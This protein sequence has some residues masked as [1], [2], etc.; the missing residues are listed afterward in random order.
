[1]IIIHRILQIRQENIETHSSWRMGLN[2][3]GSG[4]WLQEKEM[5]GEYKFGLMA[6]AM[7]D[8]GGKIKPTEEADWSMLMVT[9]MKGTGLT[10][11]LMDMVCI[12]IWMGRDMRDIGRKIN[13][14]E[15]G[16]RLGLMA[17]YMMETMWM[18]RSTGRGLSAGLTQ[19]LTRE[20]SMTIIY[21]ALGLTSGLMAGSS[22]ES[23]GRTKCM[24][25]VFSSGPM[26][27]DTKEAMLMIKKKDM[28]YLN[29]LMAGNT[30]GAGRMEN[31]TEKECI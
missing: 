9:F 2:T 1:M 11:K 21:T 13:S 23:G 18:G 14:M 5:V 3:L 12:H 8:T 6:V 31:N 27:D 29:G 30:L 16:K 10:T 15:K 22:Q 17:H 26:E 4:V 25:R 19:P 7:K 24:E 20:I 28:V